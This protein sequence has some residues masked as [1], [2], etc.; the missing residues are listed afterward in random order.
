MDM[1]RKDGTRFKILRCVPGRV[2]NHVIMHTKTV[3]MVHWAKQH[4]FDQ[5]VVESMM[6]ETFNAN[7]ERYDGKTIDNE[8]VA[9][10]AKDNAAI[11]KVLVDNIGAHKVLVRTN[12]GER[13]NIVV[14]K[15]SEH[16]WDGEGE[17]RKP[18]IHRGA[19]RQKKNTPREGAT[20]AKGRDPNHQLKRVKQV[21]R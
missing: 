13:D 3:D 8:A 17:S 5:A 7:Y 14:T 11:A 1:T 4:G 9:T 21:E 18:W 16:Q 19:T 12:I 2:D 10:G 6:T 15:S 20:M